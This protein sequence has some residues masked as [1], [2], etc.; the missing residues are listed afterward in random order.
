MVKNNDK[1]PNFD[2]KKILHKIRAALLWLFVLFAALTAA[3][4]YRKPNSQ[5][6]QDA[7]WLSLEGDVIH[8]A[9]A[10]GPFFLYFWGS[11]CGICRYTSPQV[12]ALHDQGYRVL[13]IAVQSGEADNVRAYMREHGWNFPVAND[14]Q[15]VISAQFSLVVTPTIILVNK[16][17]MV[18][19]SSGWSS[20]W[21]L[22]A[23]YHLFSLFAS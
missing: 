22:R 21:G 12:Q 10:D 18:F 2:K 7:Y 17:K 3:D 4:W 1:L 13:S 16:G 11:W 9:Q 15:G 8:P 14:P 6:L 23:R 19:S 20:N 5:A